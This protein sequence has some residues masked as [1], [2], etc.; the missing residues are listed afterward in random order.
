MNQIQTL[1]KELFLSKESNKNLTLEN[2][3]LRRQ[4]NE[5]SSE[6][7]NILQK[8]E[9]D[10][11]VQNRDLTVENTRLQSKLKELDLTLKNLL[12]EKTSNTET[13][14]KYSYDH[15]N[16]RKKIIML[17]NEVENLRMNL[18]EKN[19]ENNYHARN[20]K[21]LENLQLN[22]QEKN[23]RLMDENKIL[24]N[25]IDELKNGINELE[26]EK[27]LIAEEITNVLKIYF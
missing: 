25:Q 10:L 13:I 18:N 5:F 8:K 7:S 24:L 22:Y 19:N 6:C 11:T 3:K 12:H 23:E 17:E 1:E 26:R 16:S 15:E 20:T 4:F 21:E 9:E 14:Q 27:R 2:E